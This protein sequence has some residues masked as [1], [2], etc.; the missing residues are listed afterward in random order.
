MNSKPIT[1]TWYTLRF[2]RWIFRLVWNRRVAWTLV[3]VVSLLTLYYQWENRRSAHELQIARER[4][5]ERIGT[6]N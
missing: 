6:E 2:A 1:Q 4:L 3:C 5:L